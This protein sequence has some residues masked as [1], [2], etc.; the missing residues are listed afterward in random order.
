MKSIISIVGFV[1]VEAFAWQSTFHKQMSSAKITTTTTIASGK[2]FVLHND[3][4]FLPYA[5]KNDRISLNLLRAHIQNNSNEDTQENDDEESEKSFNSESQEFSMM[6]Q[7]PSR[8]GSKDNHRKSNRQRHR[9]KLK[10]TSRLK[11]HSS[12]STRSSDNAILP[13]ISLDGN[14]DQDNVGQRFSGIK[15]SKLKSRKP[16]T[17][18][19]R[20]SF[21][22]SSEYDEEEVMSDG[23]ALTSWD[24]FFSKSPMLGINDFSK[25]NNDTNSNDDSFEESSYSHNGRFGDLPSPSSL[26]GDGIKSNADSDTNTTGSSTG[27]FLD[28]VLPVSELFYRS[29]QSISASDKTVDENEMENEGKETDD[30]ELPFS[31]EQSN[32]ILTTNNK[33]LVRRNIANR[34]QYQFPDEKSLLQDGAQ[35]RTDIAKLRASAS[36]NSKDRRSGREMRRGKTGRRTRNDRSY[37]KGQGRKMVRRGMEM[38]VGGEPINADP[39]LRSVDLSYCLETANSLAAAGLKGSSISKINLPDWAAVVT[40]NSRDFG[41]LLHKTSVSNVSKVSREIYCEHFVSSSIKWNVCPKDLKSLVKQ[42]E[43]SEI[44]YEPDNDRDIVGSY[45]ELVER[46]SNV[47]FV[48]SQPLEMKYDSG[49]GFG[50]DVLP[51]R[52]HINTFQTGENVEKYSNKRKGQ[53]SVFLGG[54]LK[55]TLGVTRTELESGH[56]GGSNKHILRKVLGK[57]ISN[58]IRAESLGFIVGIGNLALNEVD[59][60]STE[61]RV[62]FSLSPSD[63]M[64]Y[65]EL[66]WAAKKINLALAQSMDDGEMALAMAAAAKDEVAWPVKV[67]NRVVDEFLLEAE[68]IEDDRIDDDEEDDDLSSSIA[69]RRLDDED[70]FET[71]R[72]NLLDDDISISFPSDIQGDDNN[73]SDF[74]GP[75]GMPGDT[76]YSKDDIFL[77][78]GNGGVFP[79][80]SP[81]GLSSSPYSGNLGPLLVDA[82]VQKALTRQPRVIAIGDVHGCIDEL[83]ALLRRCDYR[84]GDLVV[85]LGDLVSKGPDSTSVVQ[86]ARELGAIGVRGNHDFE[87]I[88]WHQAIKSGAEPPVIGSEHYQIASKLSTADLR[89][90]YSLPWYISSKELNALFVHAGFVSGIRLGKQNPRLMMNMRSILPDGTV[91]SKF[92]NNWPWARLWDGPHTVLFGHDADRGLQQYEHA[93][94][95]DTGCVYG[96]RLTAC[97]LPEK[98]LVSVSAKREYFQYRRKHFD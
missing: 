23:P 89:W 64:K 37:A 74:D 62:E 67:R 47:E 44:K 88:R 63:S 97:I 98:R 14:Q 95:L 29:T 76:I 20:D 36:D 69:S 66:E 24:E 50:K 72:E 39:P 1:S 6:L 40:T 65:G 48:D 12:N 33:I 52:K 55:F 19:S 22:S 60:G 11:N 80:Y 42:Y 45:E 25:T 54:E 91:T 70:D 90:M 7:P 21:K 31:A 61:F 2:H 92:F 4:A 75:F 94:G 32:Q 3:H 28:G 8:T 38:L 26:F 34:N 68:D 73:G 96:G 71:Q 17:K 43:L 18:R 15:R 77:G 30:E 51:K 84:P 59:G 56:D 53:D 79:D 13:P 58:A 85:F 93:I 57:G 78:G 41:P 9:T 81:D 5:S 46:V 83:Q 82:V 10:S 49:M 86:M 16:K 35:Y 27:S 87:V